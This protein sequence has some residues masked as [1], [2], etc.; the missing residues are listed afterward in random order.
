MKNACEVA[1][2]HQWFNLPV[3]HRVDL[4][5]GETICIQIHPDDDANATLTDVQV[6]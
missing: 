2:G 3:T 4:R 6:M 5:Q 1:L